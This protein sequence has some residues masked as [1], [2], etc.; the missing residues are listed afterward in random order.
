MNF[1]G[2]VPGEI[3]ASQLPYTVTVTLFA[4]DADAPLPAETLGGRLK[5]D[6]FVIAQ[7]GVP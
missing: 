3:S 2:S 5:D 6:T 7:V 4:S 1:S